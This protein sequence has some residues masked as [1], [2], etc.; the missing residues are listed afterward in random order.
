MISAHTSD[1]DAPIADDEL[2][3]STDLYQLTMLQTYFEHR[4]NGRAVFELHF[5]TMP[6]SRSFLVAAGLAT[7]LDR[8]ERLAFSPRAIEALRRTAIFRPAFLEHLA[9]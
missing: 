3:L 1:P 2:A 5:R 4:T 6:E 7:A 8:L 9:T